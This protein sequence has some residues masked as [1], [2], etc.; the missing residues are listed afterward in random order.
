M[1]V[2]LFLVPIVLVILAVKLVLRLL[3][4]FGG[5]RHQRHGWNR[6]GGRGYG[7]G[8]FG[9]GSFGVGSI[10]PIFALVAL[11]RLFDRRW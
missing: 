9:M 1:L 6:Y 5:F 7:P 4:G 3:F 8:G 10:L 11:E 2:L